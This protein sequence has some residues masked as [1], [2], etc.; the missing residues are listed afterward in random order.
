MG[1]YLA[2]V[3]PFVLE[4]FLTEQSFGQEAIWI[5]TLVE[6]DN[7]ISISVRSQMN[8]TIVVAETVEGWWASWRGGVNGAQ[9]AYDNWSQGGANTISVTASTD[10]KL[11]Y[12]KNRFSYALSTNMRY[13]KARIAEEGTRK[14]D[15]RIAINNKFSYLFNENWRGFANVN[16]STQFD[17]GYD[18]AGP[19][20]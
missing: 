15:D 7:G 11:L 4:L 3:L 5:S 13:G 17:Q 18:Y 8:A 20:P 9:A 2:V 16:F 14:T 19:A 6:S 1:R 10:F 12:R